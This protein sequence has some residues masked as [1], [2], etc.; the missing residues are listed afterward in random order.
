MNRACAENLNI[1]QQE[2]CADSVRFFRNVASMEPAAV[3]LKE[4][5]NRA[6]PRF[7]IRRM[8]EWLEMTPSSYAYYEDPKQF[9]KPHLP[10]ELARKLVAIFPF[11]A[12]ETMSLAGLDSEAGDVIP[13]PPAQPLQLVT[14]QVALPSEAALAR[15]FEGLLRPLDRNMP[16]DALARILARRL[17]TAFEQLR[18]RSRFH[19]CG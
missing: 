17:P 10:L 13:V 8:A 7:T 3:R 16:V 11:S 4:M 9:K 6:G 15:M 5:R 14:M 19:F 1:L 18:D 12:A 2:N